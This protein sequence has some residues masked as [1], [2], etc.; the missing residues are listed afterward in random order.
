M[1]PKLFR[2]ARKNWKQLK[3]PSTGKQNVI[4]DAMKFYSAV[5][6]NELLIYTTAWMNCKD[7]MS[8][9]RNL[10]QE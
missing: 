8:S 2:I 3:Y 7:V 10:A 4:V 9:D 5:K 6:G 1:N